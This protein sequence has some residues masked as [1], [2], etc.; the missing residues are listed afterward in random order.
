MTNLS[1][2]HVGAMLLLSDYKL[3]A[4]LF[5]CVFSIIVTLL[6]MPSVINISKLKNL[7]ASENGR[8]SHEGKVPNLGGIGVFVGFLGTINIIAILFADHGQ[9]RNLIIFN[10]LISL[11][12]LVGVLD[13][14]LSVSPRKKLFYQLIVA[15]IFTVTTNYHIDS[16]DGLFGLYDIPYSLGIIFSV[17]VVV[18]IINAY[19]LIDGIDGLAGSVGAIIS[20]V[21]AVVFYWSGYSLYALL[22]LALMGSLS[23]FLIYNFSHNR[24]IFLGDTGSM[25]VGFALAVLV[26]IYLNLSTNNSLPLFENAPLFVLALLSYPLLDTLRV[27]IV[28]IKNGHSPFRADRNHIH[29]RL[30]DLGL[31]HKIATVFVVI[32]TIVVITMAFL[33][34][35]LSI[36]IA[37]AI[38]VPLSLG[39]LGL[40]YIIERKKNCTGYKFAR[41][42]KLTEHSEA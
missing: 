42:W 32:Y 24:K 7:T 25:I 8:T 19:N 27:F 6:I 21:M 22:S 39:I 41:S 5:T 4:A 17:F 13:D 15:F 11:L 10:I 33:L 30:I 31:S 28:R 26:L 37:F 16:F 23:A 38:L 34:K 2:N 14:I 18:L 3:L 1:A 29:H 20:L 36:N 40:P 12:F 35:D 9:L